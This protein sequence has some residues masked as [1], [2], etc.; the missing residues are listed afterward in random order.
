MQ[1]ILIDP[2]KV[3]AVK[4]RANMRGAR[5]A[6]AMT[7]AAGEYIDPSDFTPSRVE[8]SNENGGVYVY[9][10]KAF[11][12]ACGVQIDDVIFTPAER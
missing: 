10:V 11:C 4:D 8:R 7:E 1:R 12:I 9:R 3:D 5:L 2:K 6:N